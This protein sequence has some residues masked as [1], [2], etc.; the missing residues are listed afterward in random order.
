MRAA[1]DDPGIRNDNLRAV[2]LTGLV[3]FLLSR[4]YPGSGFLTDPSSTLAHPDIAP[5]DRREA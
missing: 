4:P 5:I 3:P 2:L 1:L